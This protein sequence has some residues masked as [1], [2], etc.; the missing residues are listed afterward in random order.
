MLYALFLFKYI[1]H[2]LSKYI[3]IFNVM[4]E[5]NTALQNIADSKINGEFFLMC[6]QYILNIYLRK[7]HNIYSIPFLLI[8]WSGMACGLVLHIS[9]FSSADVPSIFLHPLWMSVWSEIGLME[10][11]IKHWSTIAELVQTSIRADNYM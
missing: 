2:L 8:P 3:Y 4:L 11:V 5:C 9:L 7:H 1:W 10:A 6:Y